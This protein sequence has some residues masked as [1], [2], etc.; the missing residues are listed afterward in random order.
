MRSV[1][2]FSL[3]E[4]LIV[5]TVIAIIAAIAIPNLLAARRA[6]N[7]GSAASSLRTL[8]GANVSYAATTGSGDYAG[9]PA[10]VGTSSL[11]DLYDARLIDGVLGAGEKNGYLFVGDRTNASLTEPATFYFST[12]PSITSGVLMTGT[13]RFGVAT[14]GV[15]RVDA[16][17]ATLATAF[18]AVSLAAA[19]PL[20]N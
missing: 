15:L 18:D 16:A 13:K 9:L 5:V 1:R 7:E 11:S 6:A 12:N 8:H 2:G 4:L 20:D 14:D 19:A 17:P 10:T 3:I